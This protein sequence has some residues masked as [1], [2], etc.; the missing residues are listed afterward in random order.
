MRRHIGVD[1]TPL[2]VSREY[3]RL[4]VAGLITSLGSQATYVTIPFQLKQLTHSP[5]AVGALG[6]FEL[7][8]LVVFGLYGGVLA[9]R[10]NRRRLIITMEGLLMLATA[11]VLV[12]AVVPHPQVWVLYGDAFVAAAVSSLQRPSIEALNQAFVPHELQRAAST[13]ANIRYSTASIIGPALGGLIAVAAS[14]GFVYGANLVTFAVSLVL[15]SGL[16]RQLAPAS[17]EDSDRAA[18]RAGLAFLRS[19]PDIVGT[20]IID[21]LAMTFAFPVAMLPFVAARFPETYALSLLYCGLPAG[22]LVFTL[23]SGAGGSGRRR[24]RRRP[25]GDPAGHDVERVHPPR[26][27]RPHGGD[28]DDF[29]LARSHRRSV[30]RR[31]HGRLDESALLADL[32]RPGLQRFGGRR[33][34]GPA[35]AVALR[36]APRPQRR[37]RA[38]TAGERRMVSRAPA[39]SI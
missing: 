10:L 38:R 33:G 39:P 16:S 3:R 32:R 30:P 2:R 28:G 6:L 7:I 34:G 15:L 37:A 4:Y 29:V 18:L 14:P 31:G 17:A 24:G 9:D 19:R 11:V 13:L 36:R 25:V 26:G 12:N 20:Y 35:V 23:L 21:L 27:A 22:A 8:P 5:L 1:L